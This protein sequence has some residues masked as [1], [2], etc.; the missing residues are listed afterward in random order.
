[1]GEKVL[2]GF[3]NNPT[4]DEL[5]KI[6]ES[7]AARDRR[8][9]LHSKPV[10]FTLQRLGLQHPASLSLQSD[11][12]LDAKIEWLM[13]MDQATRKVSDKI[14]QVVTNGMQKCQQVE[15]FNSEG[16]HAKDERNYV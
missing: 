13:R 1:Y 9:P 8:D 16:L 4:I 10:D 5:K 2:Y 6:T 15:I 11:H 12:P 7:L 14:V 3:T